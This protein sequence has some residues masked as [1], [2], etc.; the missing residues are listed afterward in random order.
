M[1]LY[2]VISLLEQ[3]IIKEKSRFRPESHAPANCLTQRI[4]DGYQRGMNTGV[5]FVDLSEAYDTVN[6]LILIQKLY[7]LTQYSQLCR[8]LQNF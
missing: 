2:R 4:V 3:H 8:V 5:A 1:I 6:H 7:N